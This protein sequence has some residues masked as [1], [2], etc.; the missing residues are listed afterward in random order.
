M[1]KSSYQVHL[2]RCLIGRSWEGRDSYQNHPGFHHRLF[3]TQNNTACERLTHLS[4]AEFRNIRPR[5]ALVKCRIRSFFDQPTAINEKAPVAVCR[6]NDVTGVAVAVL[7]DVSLCV[8]VV[9]W[10]VVACVTEAVT[11]RV[12]LIRVG[13]SWTVVGS[14]SDTCAKR[15]Q[16][17]IQLFAVISSS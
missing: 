6:S 12:A 7:I 15:T 16:F 9:V 4:F 14:I 17:T 10:A 11:V 3:E 8:I 13:H 5:T 2:R 1:I